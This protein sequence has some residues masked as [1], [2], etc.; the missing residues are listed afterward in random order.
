M[1]RDQLEMAVRDKLGV[2]MTLAKR[3]VAAA[4]EA[5]A[6]VGAKVG[7]FTWYSVAETAEQLEIPTF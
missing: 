2:G 1:N 3:A 4:S 6:I 7:R 5:G